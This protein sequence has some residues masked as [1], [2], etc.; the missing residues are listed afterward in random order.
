MKTVLIILLFAVIAALSF[1]NLNVDVNNIQSLAILIISV[2]GLGYSLRP[3]S[4]IN[5][6]KTTIL[7]IMD[8]VKTQDGVNQE[9][10]R[11]LTVSRLNYERLLK[12]HNKLKETKS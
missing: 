8:V 9:L 3:T 1:Y 12:I 4:L 2:F 7:D 5:R 6:Y 10:N 11:Q